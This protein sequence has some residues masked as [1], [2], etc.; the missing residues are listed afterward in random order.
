MLINPCLTLIDPCL[1]TKPLFSGSLYQTFVLRVLVPN[2]CSQGLGTKPLFSGQGMKTYIYC[3]SW[4]TWADQ[5]ARGAQTWTLPKDFILDFLR[6]QKARLL[7]RAVTPALLRWTRCRCCL[8]K[9]VCL[10]VCVCVCVMYY[11]GHP[12]IL[13][14]FVYMPAGCAATRFFERAHVLVSIKTFGEQN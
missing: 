6:R 13:A 2:L 9:S 10:C 8:V 1:G 4:N 5:D 12:G 11:V 7:N 3:C 14:L